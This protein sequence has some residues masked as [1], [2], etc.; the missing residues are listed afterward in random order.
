MADMHKFSL[1]L[2]GEQVAALK[3]A[4]ETG[5]YATTYFRGQ[6]NEERI[7]RTCCSRRVSRRPD[8]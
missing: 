5:E 2:T 8:P 7:D 6:G 1:A 4:V 3:G